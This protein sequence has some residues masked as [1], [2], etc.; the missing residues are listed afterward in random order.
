MFNF[1]R[2]SFLIILTFSFQIF[3]QS[4][5]TVT[6]NGNPAGD[7][8]SAEKKWGGDNVD[9]YITFDNDYLYISAHRVNGSTFNLYDHLHFYLDTDPQTTPT[10][11]SGSTNGVT[12]D[13]NTPTLPFNADY[14]LSIRKESSYWV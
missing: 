10:S 8:N 14:R 5:N 9:Y 13:G 2:F 1:Q 6:F 4:N 7:F 12:W 3:G 11:G